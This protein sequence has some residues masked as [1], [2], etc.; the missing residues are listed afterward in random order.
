MRRFFIPA[1]FAVLVVSPVFSQTMN[2]AGQSYKDAATRYASGFLEPAAPL[3]LDA[4]IGF[5]FQFNAELSAAR[6]ELEAVDA[7]IQQARTRPNPGVAAL[8]E[9]TRQ[10]TRI[11]TLQLNQPI[12][13]GGKRAARIEAATRG[14]DAAAVDLLA[15]RADI[16]AAVITA[17]FDVVVAQ[18][19]VRL[20]EASAGLAQRATKA[21]SNRVTAGKIS[22]V[23]ETKA[24]VAEA[25]VRV[26]Q[27]QALSELASARKRLTATWGNPSPRF[28]RADG[29]VETLPALPSLAEL[30][31]R[32]DNAPGVTRARLEIKRRQALAGVEKSRQTPNVTVI[33][34]AKRDQQQGRNQ[35]VLGLSIPLPL[36]DR[37]QGNL[38]EA[39]RRTDKARDEL[40]AVESRL[41]GDLAQAHERLGAALQEL[42]LL[43]KDI[44]P[45]ASSAFDAATKGFEAG[46]FSFL[47]VLDAQRTLFLAK[48]QYLRALSDAHRAAADIDRVLG[49]P[50]TTPSAIKP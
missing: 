36:F 7:T 3:T 4:A 30:S 39:L 13:L 46:K 38:L 33:L 19:R 26:E 42:G 50:L 32:F 45:G 23:E 18:E 22:P 49:E 48:S 11:T 40:V 17:Y 37:N 27:V 12:E 20:A 6:H 47:D 8:V 14:R 2:A 5:A 29:A 43:Q 31:M 16:R 15:K 28:E 9:D 25:N 44:L 21:A 35:A 34:G 24:R 41:N 10:S 1:W